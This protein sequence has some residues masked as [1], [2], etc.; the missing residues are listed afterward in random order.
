MSNLHGTFVWYELMTTDMKAAEDFYRGVIGWA[1]RDSGVPD[2]SY[3]LFTM[4]ERPV[5]GVMMLPESAR[6]A[7]ARPGWLGYVA[8]EDVDAS[9]AKVMEA[10]G[11]VHRAPGDIP[12]VGRFAFV[13]DP[14]G[15]VFALF[16]GIGEA[17]PPVAPGTPGHAGWHE[18]YA[19]DWP[20]TFNFYAALFGWVKADAID[21]GPMGTYQLIARGGEGGGSAFGGMMT[22]PD[23]VPVP[24]WNYYFNVEAIDSAVVRVIAGGGQIING[25]YQ[26]PG[27]S[28]IIQGLD[29]Q[30]AMFS[31][32]AP[33]R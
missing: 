4:G 33:R 23:T 12:G 29:P 32:V 10:G 6:E 13:G 9:A 8:V 31:L 1:A 30:G 19:A 17:P 24:F 25:P 18:L 26:V 22:K 5:G 7:G 3:T 16:R 28:W 2:V 14:Q 15:A 21:M 27:G 11:T 20:T